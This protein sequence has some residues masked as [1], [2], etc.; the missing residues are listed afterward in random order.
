MLELKNISKSFGSKK[1]INSLDLTIPDGSILA[2]VGPSGG[3]KT[4]LL[5]TLAGLETVDSGD[6]LLDG[7]KFDPV[8]S[9]HQEQVV[10]VVFQE[11]ELF[12]H[13]SVFENIVLAPKL[14]LKE[15]K[16]A[17]TKKAEDIAAQLGIESLMQQYPYQLS[18]G[19]KQRVAIARA[20]AMDPKVLAYDEPTSALDPALREHVEQ[21]ILGLKQQGVTQLVVTHDM[22]F[23]ENIADNLLEVEEI[24]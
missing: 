18:G 8:N 21:I 9:K 10:G 24:K 11:F 6:F 16:D 15:E 22:T 19:Q 14:A 13:L 20:M 7:E 17:Y 2:I 23:A 4:T 5:R 3:G 1:V 12:P